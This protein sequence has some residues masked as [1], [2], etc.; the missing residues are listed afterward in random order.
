M[1]NTVSKSIRHKKKVLSKP[2]TLAN[3]ELDKEL[4]NMAQLYHHDKEQLFSAQNEEAR[5]RLRVERLKKK[6]LNPN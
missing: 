4:S 1:G 5:K 2:L 6:S 3:N